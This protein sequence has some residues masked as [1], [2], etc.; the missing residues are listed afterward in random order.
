MIIRMI[1]TL[2]LA[3]FPNLLWVV[4]EDAA[5]VVLLEDLQVHGAR[6]GPAVELVNA[7]A[8]ALQGGSL[9]CSLALARGS[10]ASVNAVRLD[11]IELAGRSLL[12]TR[13]MEVEPFVEPG[14]IWCESTLAPPL[15]ERHSGGDFL[16]L[17]GVGSALAFLLASPRLDF[18][19]P[20]SPLV[21]GVLLLDRRGLSVLGT[22][23]LST[24]G[25]GQWPITLPPSVGSLEV[26]AL[27]GGP[28][29]GSWMLSEV[30]RVESR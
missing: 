30:R 23:P 28:V 10:C 3:E 20:A 15:L 17:E 14:S 1:E 6:P 16:V 11:G 27:V 12:E 22:L 4:V 9:E 21:E 26:Q 18:V 29:R 8:V 5:G 13:G 2:R 19:L 7:R 24:D 25:R